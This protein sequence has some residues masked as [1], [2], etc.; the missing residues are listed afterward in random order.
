MKPF[1]ALMI[2]TAV[3]LSPIAAIAPASAQVSQIDVHASI[4]AIMDAGHRADRVKTIKK[5]PSVGVIRLDMGPVISSSSI[6]DQSEYRIMVS[7]NAAGVNKL[8]RALAANP[9]TRAALAKR[10][11]S[12]SQVAGAQISSN[13]SLRLYIF[14][15]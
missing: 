7:R 6:P 5:V 12:P 15:R 4:S 3:A 11:I 2:A 10:G 9:A 1:R 13:G 8:R 14:S